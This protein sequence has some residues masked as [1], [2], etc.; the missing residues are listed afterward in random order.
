M[1]KLLLSLALV[2]SMG[3]SITAL[4]RTGVE[5]ESVEPGLKNGI[6]GTYGGKD[7]C[8]CPDNTATCYCNV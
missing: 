3:V 5:T 7:V 1:K 6:K 8:H 2:A 4:A